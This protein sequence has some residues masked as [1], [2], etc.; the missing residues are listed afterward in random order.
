MLHSN[1]GMANL[2][3]PSLCT[4]PLLTYSAHSMPNI[5]IAIPTGTLE[6]L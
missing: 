1:N 6:D 3:F 5:P 4:P 2:S